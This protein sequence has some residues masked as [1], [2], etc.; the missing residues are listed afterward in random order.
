MQE[1]NSY[2]GVMQSV[3][4]ICAVYASTSGNTEWVVEQV[5]HVWQ[6]AGIT[7]ELHR[8]EQADPNIWKQYDTFLLATSTWD[9]GAINPF[10]S[11][12]FEELKNTDCHN[13]RA[14]FIGMGD[15]RYEPVLFCGG[16]ESLK[17]RWIERGGTAVS[18][19]LK[20]NGEPFAKYDAVIKPWADA[21]LKLINVNPENG[22]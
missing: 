11:V 12:L 14:A 9:H 2:Y 21:L 13:K 19:P 10:F 17:N 18:T 4:S 20:F 6:E 22:S 1:V 16:M 7:V 5:V 3:G 8:A 15:V